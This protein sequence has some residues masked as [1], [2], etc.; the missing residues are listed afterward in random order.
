M[1]VCILGILHFFN[2]DPLGFKKE[3][4]PDDYEYLCI[5]DWEILT[6]IRH[7]LHFLLGASAVMFSA[8]KK[9]GRKSG[10]IFVWHY[11]INCDDYGS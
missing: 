5:H 10:I 3:I 2:L 7:I 11:G 1:I 4:S 9:T 6:H 8:E